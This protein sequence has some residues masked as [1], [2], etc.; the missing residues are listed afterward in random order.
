M[1]IFDACMH[2][3]RS[4]ES[5]SERKSVTAIHANTS[6]ASSRPERVVPIA[7]SLLLSNS[8][9]HISI[10]FV[11]GSWPALA[12]PETTHTHTMCFNRTFLH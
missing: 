6:R 3:W 11:D 8:S 12:L 4:A 5:S 1:H 10:V 2:A 9:I 7:R